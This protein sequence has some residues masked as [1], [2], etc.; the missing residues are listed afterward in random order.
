MIQ[1]GKPCLSPRVHPNVSIE[2]RETARRQQAIRA[3]PG[4]L[5]DVKID[6]RDGRRKRKGQGAKIHPFLQLS[7]SGSKVNRFSTL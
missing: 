7:E 1:L 5:D 6:E 4:L 2:Y 3:N